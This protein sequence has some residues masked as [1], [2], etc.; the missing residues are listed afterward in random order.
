MHEAI[1]A[2]R[3]RGICSTVVVPFDGPLV[4]RLR[5]DGVAVFIHPYRWW[6]SLAPSRRGR[7]KNIVD[8]ANVFRVRRLAALIHATAAD[9]VI[10]NTMTIALPALAARK[11]RVPNIWYIREY[12]RDDHS[13]ELDI[14]DRAAYRLIDRLSSAVVVNSSS[15]R[16]YLLRHGVAKAEAVSYAV[17][18]P[19]GSVARPRRPDENLHLVL[20]GAV[21]PGKGQE[22]AVRALAA[23]RE[24]GA[25]ADLTFVG[26]S[27]ATFR[28][29][30]SEVAV[31]VGVSDHVRFTGFLDDPYREIAAA[32]VCLVCSRREAF[33]RATIEAMKCGRAVIGAASGATAELIQDGVTGL[34][35]EPGNIG[36]L[37]DAIVRLDRDPDLLERLGEQA[38]AWATERFTSERYG[39]DLE[40]VIDR[41]TA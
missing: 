41:V 38:R 25:A 6:M 2:L 15:L 11:A 5:N 21:K 19:A 32:D 18:V 14:G 33:G 7:I 17:N 24:A 36:A 4:D 26:S 16:D 28:A 29:W 8:L 10:T 13:L 35:Y 39:R 27:L 37:R 40:R 20:V 12:G 31:A 9:V 30:V 23:A 34:L 22:E 3:E 1:G